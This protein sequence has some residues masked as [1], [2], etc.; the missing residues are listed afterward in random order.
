MYKYAMYLFSVYIYIFNV[1][2]Y[3]VYIYNVYIDIMYM[4]IL[5]IFSVYI[6]TRSAPQ[7]LFAPQSQICHKIEKFRKAFPFPGAQKPQSNHHSKAKALIP[8]E[9]PSQTQGDSSQGINKDGFFL[10]RPN[11]RQERPNPLHATP[12][13]FVRLHFFSWGEK[14][15]V[16][17]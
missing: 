13:F 7:L 9:T 14:Q 4:Y 12:A 15:R 1:H 17:P 16:G 3:N 6:Q 8:L 10:V 2:I 5:Y 11:P